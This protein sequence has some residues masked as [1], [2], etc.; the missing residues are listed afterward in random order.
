MRAL[1]AGAVVMAALAGAAPAQPPRHAPVVAGHCQAGETT[2]YS[3]RFGANH[4]SVCAAPGRIAYRFG[5]PGKP[6]IVIAS[7]PDWSNVHVGRIT[8]GGGG[9]QD[10]VRFTAAGHDYAVFE[11]IGGE[12]TEVSGERW[13]G[14]HVQHGTEELATLSCAQQSRGGAA[15]LGHARDFAPADA[16]R[17]IEESDPRFEAWF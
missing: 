7:M 16:L 2:L 9:S 11:A 17:S 6:R 12:L 4:G 3:C 10:H 1:L 14:I 5:P 13:S 15:G 8:G